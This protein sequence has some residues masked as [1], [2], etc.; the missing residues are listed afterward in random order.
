MHPAALFHGD[1]NLLHNLQSKALESRN[2]HRRIRQ[3]PNP[4]N[5]K[6]RQYLPAQSDGP[7]NPPSPCLRAFAHPQFLVQNQAGGVPVE[8]F[9]PLTAPPGWKGDTSCGA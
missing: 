6:V 4:M 3:Q 2:V 9:I 7:Q 5:A 1:G 8:R